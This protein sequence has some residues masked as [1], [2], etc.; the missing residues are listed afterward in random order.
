MR[1]TWFRK[2]FRQDVAIIGVLM[3]VSSTAF[4]Q[5]PAAPAPPPSGA[6]ATGATAEAERVIVTGSNIPTAEEVGPNPVTTLNRD[7]IQKTGTVNVDAV[8]ERSARKQL[9]QY[10]DGEQWHEPGRP[11]RVYLGG[12]ARDWI[13]QPAWSWWTGAV[14]RECSVAP[15]SISIRSRLRR[16]RASKF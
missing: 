3:F 16:L 12:V 15:L 13:P 7:Y 4:A 5:V 10:P 1:T 14:L 6:P 11:G 9:K 2:S 8:A